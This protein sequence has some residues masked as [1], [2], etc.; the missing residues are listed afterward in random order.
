MYVGP[1]TATTPRNLKSAR[2]RPDEV[3]LAIKTEINRGH[4][5]GPFIAPPFSV[6]HCSPLGAV[7]K[8]PCNPKVRLI[9]DLSQPLGESINEGIIDEFC[10]VKYT[11]FDAAVDMVKSI[12]WS[13]S[14]AKMDIK[15]AFRLCPVRKADWPLLC[16]TWLGH[17]FVDT[18]LPF[19]SRSSPAIFNN[20]ADV[21]TWVLI[22]VG[23]ILHIV[24]YLDDYLICAPNTEVCQKWMLTLTYIFRDIGIPIAGDKTVGPTTKITYLG[25]EIDTQAQ[26]IRLPDEKY[27]ALQK[28]LGDWQGRKKCTKQELLSLIGSLSFAAKVVKPGRI[29]LRRLID[30]AASVHKLSHHISLNL[31][32]R[33][34]IQWWLDFLPSWNGISFFQEKIISS[35]TLQLFTDA[36]NLGM[37]GVFNNRWFSR[38]WPA[39]FSVFDINFKEIFAIFAA[40]ATWAKLLKNKQI[41][42]YCDNLNIV[43]VWK[44]GTCKSPAIMRVTR[45]LFFCCASHNIN[46]LT[47]HIAGKVNF[48]ADALSRIQVGK[49]LQLNP[50][51]ESEPAEVPNSIWDI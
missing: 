47:E 30:L 10:S 5:S 26:C 28:L 38:K 39:S 16:Y 2:D 45:A 25:I 35:D 27:S 51:A 33:H 46:L 34:D 40:I 24:H 19:G 9:L 1:I 4:T 48:S 20:F 23:G 29:F 31:E 50:E 22:F 49:F 15:H 36:S 44:T 37:G 7:Q 14:L 43:T 18:R 32:A 8:D 17:F 21:L 41:L 42:V 11:P 12:G 3:S 6:T 13:A